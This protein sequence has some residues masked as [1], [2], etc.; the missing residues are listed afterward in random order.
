[1]DNNGYASIRSTQKKFFGGTYL[2]C[3][4]KTGLAFPNWKELF[5]AY[6]IP[7]QHLKKADIQPRRL[8]S[9]LSRSSGPEAWIVEIDPEQ[10]NWP[11]I[12]SRLANDGSMESSPIYDMLPKLPP[13]IQKQTTYFLEK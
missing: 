10:T 11:I 13:E 3:D 7:C 12:S 6:D 2:G 1:M 4:P 5:K 8:K 9:I